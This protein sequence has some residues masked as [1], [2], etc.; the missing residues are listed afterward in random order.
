M[1]SGRPGGKTGCGKPSDTNV[2]TDPRVADFIFAY[3]KPH[4]DDLIFH[5][6]GIKTL[7]RYIR[8]FDA[9]SGKDHVLGNSI[10]NVISQNIYIPN[11]NLLLTYQDICMA[12][13]SILNSSHG[14]G[15]YDIIVC[16]P[17]WH[18]TKQAEE[19]YW[20]LVNLLKPDGVLFFLINNVFCYQGRERA[21]KLLFQKFY[22]LPR[23][24]FANNF[25]MIVDPVSGE[26]KRKY[27]N[28][29]DCGI[30]VY[31]KNSDMPG[32][33]ANLNCFIPIPKNIFTGVRNR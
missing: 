21:E 14:L 23:Y 17:P 8:I 3:L 27:K 32:E 25:K 11:S 33:A 7:D 5:T 18:P 2:Y 20:F 15:N 19:I 16:N 4:F 9:C 13:K 12:G 6:Q 26:E 22:F 24:V 10:K 1:N 28:L 30:M 29:L 31:H